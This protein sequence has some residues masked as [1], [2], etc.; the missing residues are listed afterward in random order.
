[1]TKTLKNAVEYIFFLITPVESVFVV[2]FHPLFSCKLLQFLAN[3]LY[4]LL[5]KKSKPVGL[6]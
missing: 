4:C 1:M 3:N 2:L 6:L 5:S